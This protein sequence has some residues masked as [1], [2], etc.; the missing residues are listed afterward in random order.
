MDKLLVLTGPLILGLIEG[1]MVRIPC[2]EDLHHSK[3]HLA[4]E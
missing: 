4:L 2:L 3:D 1:T